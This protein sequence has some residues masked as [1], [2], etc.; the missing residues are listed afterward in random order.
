MSKITSKAFDILSAF[1]ID[2]ASLR[3]DELAKICKL[4]LSTL[5]RF[6][7]GLSNAGYLVKNHSNAKYRLGPTV[8]RLARVAEAGLPFRSLAIEWME[9]LAEKTGQTTYLVIRQGLSWL[10]LESIISEHMGVRFWVPPGHTAP[11]YA[12][13]PGKVL[14]AGLSDEEVDKLLDKI[15]LSKITPH[16]VTDREKLMK[17]L[18][19]IRSRGYHYSQEEYT[20]GVWGIGAPIINAQ[21]T[22]EA[23]ILI[24]GVLGYNGN[25]S[26]SDFV[27]LLL[28]ASQDISPKIGNASSSNPITVDPRL[29]Y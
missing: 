11:I 10:C 5:Y 27:K 15:P 24:A 25:A 22:Y 2:K 29:F 13:C 23:V 12:G 19:D 7:N 26:I 1:T 16:T 6:I 3:P 14:L 21:G 18:V 8:L 20:P 28:E 4:P 9:K 17:Q